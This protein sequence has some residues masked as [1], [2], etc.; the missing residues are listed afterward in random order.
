[1][2]ET[3]LQ[4]LVLHITRQQSYGYEAIKISKYI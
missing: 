3:Y 1:M 2:E 4:R